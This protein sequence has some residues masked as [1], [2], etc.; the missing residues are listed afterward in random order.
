MRRNFR[1]VFDVRL[2][3]DGREVSFSLSFWVPLGVS[4]S[5][6]SS[7]LWVVLK[8]KDS[9]GKSVGG[10]SK[11]RTSE[12]RGCHL[13]APSFLWRENIEGWRILS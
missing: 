9:G 11:A 8:P 3:S 2:G 6:L 4:L 13:L 12:I 10:M 7:W 1:G 5:L